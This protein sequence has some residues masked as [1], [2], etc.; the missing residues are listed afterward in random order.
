MSKNRINKINLDKGINEYFNNEIPLAL[1]IEDFELSSSQVEYIYNKV[2]HVLKFEDNERKPL[3]SKFKNPNQT[4][5]DYS[6]ENLMLAIREIK[7]TTIHK[8]DNKIIEKELND[9]QSELISRNI[10]LIY[11]CVDIFFHNIEMSKDDAIMFGISGLYEAITKYSYYVNNKFKMFA[12][13]RIIFNIKRH[14]YELTGMSWRT[15][16]KKRHINKNSVCDDYDYTEDLSDNRYDLPLSFEDYEEID[17]QEDKKLAKFA[18]YDIDTEDAKILVKEIL[19]KLS[20]RERQVIEMYYGLNEYGSMF[21]REISAECGLSI[22]GLQKRKYNAEE[23]FKNHILNQDKTPENDENE[24]LEVNDSHNIPN[25]EI[26]YK[27]H[28]VCKLI[29]AGISFNNFIIFLAMKNI[30]CT[31]DEVMNIILD[32]SELLRLINTYG[33][34]LFFIREELNAKGIFISKELIEYININSKCLNSRI[35]AYLSNR[36]SDNKKMQKLPL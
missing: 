5:K 25:L 35:Y 6:S 32:I 24:I 8:T 15:F 3:I 34:N 14:F 10:D 13:K 4:Y 36:N 29:I 19:N 30:F 17:T 22:P 12:I 7:R 2:K 23:H 33:Y 26:D 31:E 9:I 16:Q 27:Y 11:D 1:F 28:Y 21:Y 18:T 20:S